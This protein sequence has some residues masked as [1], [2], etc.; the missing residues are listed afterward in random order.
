MTPIKRAGYNQCTGGY[1]SE[2]DNVKRSFLSVR[3]IYFVRIF[4]VKVA[5]GSRSVVLDG[6]RAGY[7]YFGGRFLVRRGIVRWS[8]SPLLQVTRTARIVGS[9]FYRWIYKVIAS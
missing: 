6:L 7:V 3:G 9:I 5:L 8:S 4:C 2:L 1:F